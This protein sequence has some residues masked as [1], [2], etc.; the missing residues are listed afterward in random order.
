MSYEV[1]RVDGDNLRK[2]LRIIPI[3]I[4]GLL[5]L[6]ILPLAG[7]VEGSSRSHRTD[8]K[9]LSKQPPM[10]GL[11]NI[12]PINEPLP[13]NDKADY[14]ATIVIKGDTPYSEVQKLYEK[15]SQQKITLHGRE[16]PMTASRIV[17][18]REGDY[19]FKVVGPLSK[20]REIVQG[21]A[22][23]IKNVMGK[24]MLSIQSM[25]PPRS[26]DGSMEKPTFN[27]KDAPKDKEPD[28]FIIR[29]LI[30][31]DQA[32]ADYGVTG[33]GVVI[34]IVDT[35]VDYG[36]PDLQDKLMYY[37]GSWPTAT[38]TIR[39]P[40]VID[41]DESHLMIMQSVTPNSS[42]WLNVNGSTFLIIEPLLTSINATKDYYVGDLSSASGVFKFGMTDVITPAYGTV[43]IGVV[44]VDPDTAGNYTVAYF[45]M[46]DNGYF[47]DPEDVMVTYDGDRIIF[48]ED[49]WMSLGVAGGFFY[50]LAFALSDV[51][52]I[53]PGWDLSGNY[54]SIFYDFY[55]HG[56]SCAGAAAGSGEASILGLGIAPSAKIL[57]V[58]GLWWGNVEAG[59]LFAAGFAVDTNG[60]WFYTGNKFADIISNSWG[61][62]NFVYDLS[63][64][65]YD[66]EAMFVN[67]LMTPGFIDPDYPGVMIVFAAGNGGGGYGTVTSP[68][69]ALVPLTVGASTSMHIYTYLIG[70][71]SWTDDN[72]VSW[73][74]RGPTPVGY[75]KPDVVNVGAW[76]FTVAP[77]GIDYTDFGG[78]SYATPLTAGALALMYEEVKKAGRDIDPFTMKT[79]LKATADPLGYTPFDQGAGRVNVYRALTYLHYAIYGDIPSGASPELMMFTDT[80]PI[81]RD[82]LGERWVWSWMDYIPS[83]FLQ[84]LGTFFFP[85]S[86]LPGETEMEAFD[87]S[88]YVPDIEQGG[89][90]EFNFAMF[91][92]FPYPANFTMEPVKM[93]IRS[94]PIERS[95]TLSLDE[96]ETITYDH[97]ILS[98][99][100]VSHYADLME[101]EVYMPFTSMDIDNDYN[102]DFDTEIF[103]FVWINDTNGNGYPD[104]DERAAIDIG[105][106][107]SNHNHVQ[108]QHPYALLNSFGPNAKLVL[109]VILYRDSPYY[110]LENQKVKVKITYYQYVKADDIELYC[111]TA[112]PQPLSHTSR[113][114]PPSTP[115][116]TS[117]I[118]EP[119]QTLYVNGKIKV[120]TYAAP[121]VYQ[122][123]IKVT[124]SYPTGDTKTYYMPLSYTVYTTLSSP[125][126]SKYLTS[127]YRYFR[128]PYTFDKIKGHNDWGWRYEAG[129]WRVFYVDITTPDIWTF[130]VQAKWSDLYTS[131][132]T[133]TLG[134]D[135]QFAGLYYGESV[136]YHY[137][138]G[139]GR[140]LWMN[141]G[142]G[143]TPISRSVKTFPTTTYRYGLYPQ[144]EPVK[145]RLGVYTVIV[146]TATFGGSR[147]PEKFSVEVKP[148]R[149]GKLLPN[150]PQGTTGEV[151]T[152]LRIPYPVTSLT[153]MVGF[154]P[155]P[156]FTYQGMC[157]DAN[158]SPTSYQGNYR[159]NY[160]FRFRLEW[161]NVCGPDYRDDISVVYAAEIPYLTVYYRYGGTYYQYTDYYPFEDWVITAG[162]YFTWWIFGGPE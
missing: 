160:P 2:P 15:F 149:R 76:G 54:L 21:A 140:F 151:S 104:L 51:G 75:V 124:V 66:F 144:S 112:T 115:Q 98:Q 109:R 78:T 24:P 6:S 147:L 58:K 69:A 134:P 113:R 45:D 63:G 106:S 27:L 17:K 103:A 14:T 9:P 133:Y 102:P 59:M 39:E 41:A 36:H 108:I 67:G 96:D 122:R 77:V 120:P 53:Y 128:E 161:E 141:T 37:V 71:G 7:V 87:Y 145:Q 82:K 44:M 101:V 47:T 159:A 22:S 86:I 8:A 129:D 26:F 81:M 152:Y 48:S 20:I 62:S 130:E 52:G 123:Y 125:F 46:N 10:P 150:T 33:D 23:I 154:S 61:I 80:L 139:A 136:S 84:Y 114:R 5:I 146:R 32:Y 49:L 72:I 117:G 157:T 99:R 50:D 90:K 4:L 11:Q 25:E 89:S 56:T 31:A 30:G 162:P 142:I 91:N 105:Y 127:G 74:A 153:P 29:S 135:G 79:I 38:T 83:Y 40:L 119:G 92:K 100:S 126:T 156:Y 118:I 18:N 111:K 138:I 88:I 1:I 13:G 93:K 65:G 73:S 110:T 3:L 42:G 68:G 95:V 55:G 158:I 116:C 132:I 107:Y 148:I 94:I 137:Y 143:R 60:V 19:V 97:I 57:G 155:Y 12:L 70:Y 35:G 131:L 34:A 64:F 85:A 28:T 121:T 16:Y 43:Q